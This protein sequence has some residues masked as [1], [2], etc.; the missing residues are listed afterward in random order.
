MIRLS[1]LLSCCLFLLL[2]AFSFTL[3]AKDII[4][5][6]HMLDV[7][8]KT[9]LAEVTITIEGNKILKVEQGY[10][11]AEQGDEIIDLKAYTLMP[12]LMDMHVHL[13]TVLSPGFFMEKFV[14]D[15]A[16]YAFRSTKYAKDTLLAGFT[17]VR[18]LG[19]QD[20]NVTIALRD[21]I[22]EGYVIG[23][24][25]YTA[26]KGLATLGGLADPTNGLRME[27]MGEPDF[28]EGVINGPLSARKAVRQRFKEGADVIKLNVT[29]G[30]INQGR[31]GFG[32][33]WMQDELDAVVETAKEYEMSVAAHA[34]TP[35]G[36]IRS[37]KAGVDSIEHGT[38]MND[39]ALKLM[40][41]HGTAYVPT[42]SAM[43]WISDK[44]KDANSMPAEVRAKSENLGSQ[45]DLTVK[46]AYEK[47]LWI[48]FG[49]DAGVFPH[50]INAR[51]F[52]YMVNAGIPPM[53]ALL[54]ATIE[55]AKLL[56]IEDK[57]G[58][59][60]AGKLA[61]MVAVKGDPL[62]DIRLMQDIK[63]VMKDGVIYKHPTFIPARAE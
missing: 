52:E 43:K 24:R 25:I 41:K 33:Q 30:S 40:K 16:D 63:F 44:A 13:S 26:G 1:N 59:I 3:N 38:F 32:S 36:I 31:G 8:S 51:E 6:G 60:E 48:V 10:S 28:V 34:H 61:D 7:K 39:E 29:G 53:A 12:G 22:K 42:M 19:D 23:P 49:T 58:S 4:Y 9:I 11:K 47:G 21:A 56:K 62:N 27:F 17:T 2:S 5:A 45:I 35:I 46:K 55:A 15:S 14:M 20:H 54:S 18:E 37:V 50:G 57:L